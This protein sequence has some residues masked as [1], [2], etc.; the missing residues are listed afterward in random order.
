MPSPARGRSDDPRHRGGPVG[1]LPGFRERTS[2]PLPNTVGASN[3]HNTLAN[4][5]D[6][7]LY[8][9]G[10]DNVL[11]ATPDLPLF[12]VADAQVDRARR[13]SPDV[14]GG[15]VAGCRHRWRIGRIYYVEHDE[16]WRAIAERAALPGAALARYGPIVAP[17]QVE[18]L[19]REQLRGGCFESSPPAK[20][21]W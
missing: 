21:V 20:E 8:A 12:S 9:I 16:V 11:Y 5:R 4:A 1:I 19:Q 10:G 13:S 3:R 7:L 14:L 2:P 6:E 18:H 15:R 17:Q